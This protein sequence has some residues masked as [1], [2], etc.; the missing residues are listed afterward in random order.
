MYKNLLVP[1]DGT[2]LADKAID[3][4][5]ALAKQLGAAITAFIAEPTP[6]LPNEGTSAR[7]VSAERHQHVERTTRHARSVLA[8]F[9]ERARDAHVAFTGHHVS[10]AGIDDA[11]AHAAEQHGCD[12]IVM[13]THARGAL[14]EL[15]FGS[16]TKGVMAR[17]KLPLLVLR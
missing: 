12:M 2:D 15:V 10:T 9:A 5:L 14:G 6:P 16:H 7:L 17:S 11:I 4:S 1:V 3:G 8:R 13:A